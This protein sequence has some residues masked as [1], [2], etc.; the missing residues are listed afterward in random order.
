MVVHWAQC[1]ISEIALEV[2]L[3]FK[4]CS[5]DCRL[6]PAIGLELVGEKL[7][8]GWR[9]ASSPAVS[10]V[11]ISAWTRVWRTTSFLSPIGSCSTTLLYSILLKTPAKVQNQTGKR[12][13]KPPMLYG[14]VANAINRNTQNTKHKA[15]PL[16]LARSPIC[17]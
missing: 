17:I 5:W 8:F 6:E 13:G 9:G 10:P 2:E 11:P 16:L 1:R 3:R 15:T 14:T 12:W 4:V 7:S